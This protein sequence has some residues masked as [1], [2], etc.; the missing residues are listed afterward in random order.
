MPLARLASAGVVLSMALLAGLLPT[1]AQAQDRLVVLPTRG[2]ASISYWWMPTEGATTTVL[3]FPGGA[4]G[5]GYREGEPRSNNFLVRSRAHFRAAGFNV[6]LL[7]NPSDKRQL[8]DTWRTSD[9][10]AADARAV[11]DSIR[12][13]SPAPVWLVGT[14]RGSISATAL[15]IAL[16]RELAGVV[17]TASITSLRVP[18]AVAHQAIDTLA[19][20][21]LLYHHEQD[22]C[23]VTLAHETDR[24][25]RKLQRA[26]VKRL[27]L[28]SGGENPS[29]DACEALHWHGFIGM[30]ARA[31]ADIAAWIRQP[32]P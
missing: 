15:G 11:I 20:P 8:D 6:A 12:Q 31:V 24:I 21:V 4:G 22:A 7:G 28:V 16:Q 13:A 18:A 19:L 17:L 29:G 30:E 32:Q 26:P 3:L 27:M 25:L 1:A 10:H 14:S 2:T 9:A 5:I 23:P